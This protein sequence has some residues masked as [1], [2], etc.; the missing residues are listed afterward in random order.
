MIRLLCG[1]R[2]GAAAFGN[3]DGCSKFRSEAVSDGTSYT[4]E[5]LRDHATREET[6]QVMRR[7]RVAVGGDRKV[8]AGS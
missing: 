3:G 1:F 8:S 7:R 4:V 5:R 2:E 6:L